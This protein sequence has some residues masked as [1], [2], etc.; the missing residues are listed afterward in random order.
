LLAAL[1]IPLPS[2]QPTF[3][4]NAK[5]ASWAKDYVGIAQATGIMSGTGDNNFSPTDNYTREQSFVT[6]YKVWEMV[7]AVNADN[8]DKKVND[9]IAQYIKPGMSELDK[10]RV[11]HDWIIL[12]TVYDYRATALRG[13]GS[14]DPQYTDCYTA[15]GVIMNGRGVCQGFSAAM[16]LFMDKLGIE[17]EIVD[18]T[19][20]NSRTPDHVWNDIKI[21]GTWYE[22]DVTWDNCDYIED[23]SYDL[24]SNNKFDPLTE[25]SIE[26][27]GVS[28]CY[29]N[30]STAMFGHTD[31]YTYSPYAVC[32]TDMAY[33]KV[34]AAKTLSD[35]FS[36]DYNDIEPDSYTYTYGSAEQQELID[37]G[38]SKDIFTDD[39]FGNDWAFSYWT[40][41]W[42]KQATQGQGVSI[43]FEY[44]YSN[45][46]YYNNFMEHYDTI[47]MSDEE[48][49][50]V[51]M[52]DFTNGAMPKGGILEIRY[53]A[54][55]GNMSEKNGGNVLSSLSPGNGNLGPMVV[56]GVPNQLN[57]DVVISLGIK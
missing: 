1:N 44:A 34:L 3:S 41:K 21:D 42:L 35:Y 47:A 54:S 36:F 57:F 7:Q 11:I 30:R 20:K 10:E 31:D 16:K 40:L 38:V 18:G 6:L 28:Y 48:K 43:N 49:P 5:I 4:D 26:N 22:V 51:T 23:G 25:S 17:C 14:F 27:W 53:D 56:F 39:E 24:N 2:A 9:V 52:E 8:L 15:Y 32:N 50:A 45:E 46:Y 13:D 19:P 33:S 37:M 55:Y 29:F 12:N